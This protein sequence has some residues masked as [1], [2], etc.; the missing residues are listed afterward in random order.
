M[1]KANSNSNALSFGRDF[2]LGKKSP[3]GSSPTPATITAPTEVE[4]KTSIFW[5]KQIFSSF[6][7]KFS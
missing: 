1:E 4:E 5:K 6:N 2:L 7:E 3:I